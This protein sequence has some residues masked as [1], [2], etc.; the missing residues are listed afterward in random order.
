MIAAQAVLGAATST[1]FQ[2]GEKECKYYLIMLDLSSRAFHVPSSQSPF[3]TG[4]LFQRVFACRNRRRCSR[5][6]ASQSLK[7]IWREFGGGE[8]PSQIPT[9]WNLKC[10]STLREHLQA[11]VVLLRFRLDARARAPGAERHGAALARRRQAGHRWRGPKRG[12]NQYGYGQLC[13]C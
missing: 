2:G 13:T 6:L 1:S 10:G 7:V 3:R 12:L 11:E 4:S 8:N 5:E 9:T